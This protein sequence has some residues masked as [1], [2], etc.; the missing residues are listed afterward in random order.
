MDGE[1]I[2]LRNRTAALLEVGCL[3]EALRCG[4]HFQR[5]GQIAAGAVTAS[6]R[7]SLFFRCDERVAR[8]GLVCFTGKATKETTLASPTAQG[9]ARWPISTA[10]EMSSE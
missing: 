10:S 3:P 1:R 6:C 9:S 7:L 8:G 2:A 5:E 4:L